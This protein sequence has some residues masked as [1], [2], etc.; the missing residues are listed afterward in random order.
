M[1]T[2]LILRLDAATATGHC[3]NNFHYGKSLITHYIDAYV[4]LNIEVIDSFDVPW[5]TYWCVFDFIS[6]VGTFTKTQVS[7]REKIPILGLTPG[8]F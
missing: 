8:T 2:T 3:P 1:A 4:T 5:H 7:L 6:I